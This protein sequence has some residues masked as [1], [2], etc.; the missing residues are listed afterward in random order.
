M[1]VKTSL[2]IPSIHLLQSIH[3]PAP[4]ATPLHPVQ[5]TTNHGT[6][7]PNESGP[8]VPPIAGGVVDPSLLKPDVRAKL[9]SIQERTNVLVEVTVLP[10][11]SGS[12][13]PGVASVAGLAGGEGAFG[14]SGPGALGSSPGVG[15][16][17]SDWNNE[18]T[19]PI[20]GTTSPHGALG[21]PTGA[22]PFPGV[23]PAGGL[24]PVDSGR[25]KS[26]YP[27]F[28]SH[29]HQQ[30]HQPHQQQ[31]QHGSPLRQAE[32][33]LGEAAEGIV[34]TDSP[35]TIGQHQQPQQNQSFASTG[36]GN[37]YVVSP[38]T[39]GISLAPPNTSA[40]DPWG[41]VKSKSFDVIQQQNPRLNNNQPQQQRVAGLRSPIFSSGGGLPGG[42]GAGSVPLGMEPSSAAF[43]S[44]GATNVVDDEEILR[45]L[46]EWGFGE[47]KVC[48]VT[49]EGKE[50][51][52]R[53]AKVLLLLLIDELSGLAQENCEIDQRI[54]Y[55][56]AGRKRQT[57]NAIEEETNTNI[58]LAPTTS[59]TFFGYSGIGLGGN[60][61]AGMTPSGAATHLPSPLHGPETATTSGTGFPS[62]SLASPGLE[63]LPNRARRPSSLAPQHHRTGSTTVSPRA[64]T[65]NGDLTGG[66]QD[67]IARLCISPSGDEQQ[68]VATTPAAGG[69]TSHMIDMRNRVYVTGE[70]MAVASAREMLLRLAFTKKQSVFSKEAAVV[71]RKLDWLISEKQREIT[72]IMSDNGSHVELIPGPQAGVVRVYG[73][74]R[75]SVDRTMKHLMMLFTELTLATVFTMPIQQDG[76]HA[77]SA[78]F[79]SS[80]EAVLKMAASSTKAEIGYRSGQFEICGTLSEVRKSLPLIL[81]SDAVNNTIH[82]IRFQ[83]ELAVEHRD[84]IA[85]KRNGKITKIT[86]A[87]GTQIKFDQFNEQNFLIDVSGSGPRVLEALDMLSDELPAEISFHIP[88]SYHRRIIGKGGTSVQDVMRRHSAF[89]KFSSTEQ[90]ALFG[91]HHRNEDNVICITPNKNKHSLYNMKQD[92]MM[93]ILTKDREYEDWIININRKYHRAL[94]AET[95]AYLHHIEVVHGANIRFLPREDGQDAVEVFA[96]QYQAKVIFEQLSKVLP[97]ELT[98][99][100]NI[101]VELAKVAASPEWL[102]FTTETLQDLQVSILPYSQ[103][104]AGGESI[105]VL[106]CQ[107]QNLVRLKEARARLDGFLRARPKYAEPFDWTVG[108]LSG[109][110]KPTH[111]E[112]R[113][114]LSTIVYGSDE[115]A[116][117]SLPRSAGLRRA[118]TVGGGQYLDGWRSKRSM[119][120]RSET[121]DGRIELYHQQTGNYPPPIARPA[122]SQPRAE[123][124]Q[125]RPKLAGG[126]TQSLDIRN[127]QDF[128]GGHS[129]HA[130]FASLEQAYDQAGT[131]TNAPG[132]LPGG[133]GTSNLTTLPRYR[134][135][136]YPRRGVS[137]YDPVQE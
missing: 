31:Q 54:Q 88:E 7:T 3:S 68:Q 93:S 57:V 65:V 73:D 58:Y 26:M 32:A 72:R 102:A 70:P 77:D 42:G 128:A 19:P 79:D 60:S 103:M 33:L 75:I 22:H 117:I 87:T 43:V 27:L 133:N 98:C 135:G 110:N 84:F 95:R 62:S 101:S 37:Q 50:E 109:R 8:T 119:H 47:E 55:I 86:R 11:N 15:G 91:G 44:G 132:V 125:A 5:P 71:P 137:V 96:S 107:R 97:I 69:I 10:G 13:R 21:P 131:P 122:D 104:T 108:S 18:S 2:K 39:V 53:A 129:R 49:L 34:R 63:H 116:N 23:N 121:E 38:E 127:M 76:L 30:H 24:K 46:K 41:G 85:G 61:A 20:S 114:G 92:L 83:C 82:D 112:H 130:S 6:L 136:N 64:D 80:L 74:H 4:P 78:G 123:P 118:D 52:V 134:T 12:G 113:R 126:R 36:A 35:E 106:K 28:P 111:G 67:S 56:L 94:Q 59:T 115:L 51:N 45:D 99:S 25:S 105:F 48:L 100:F 40:T 66:L 1:Q 81:S 29:P 90:W 16:D 120:K 9:V 89:V 17:K 14:Y 124:E